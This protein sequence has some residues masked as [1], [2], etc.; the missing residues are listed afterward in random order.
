[1]KLSFLII[2]FFTLASGVS[3]TVISGKITDGKNQPIEG[4][5]VFIDGTYDGGTTN[6]NGYFLFK[7]DEIG[8]KTLKVSFVSYETFSLTKDVSELHNLQ[9]KL[10]D[11]VNALD[12]VVISAGTFSAGDNSK[13]SVLKPLDVVT[14]ASALGD[15]DG[16]LQTLPGTTTV[17]EDGRLFVRGGDATETQIFIDGIRVFTPYVPTTS[18]TPTRGRYSP[19]LFDGITFSTGGYSAEFGQALSSVLLLNTIDEPAQDKTDIALL[20][21]AAGLGHTE[22]W[23]ES[24]LSLNGSY[25]NLGPYYAI[26]PDRNDWQKPFCTASGEAVFRQTIGHGLLKVYGAFDTSAFELMQEDINQPNGVHFKLN[27]QN[28]YTNASFSESLSNDWSLM[29]GGSYTYANTKV[30]LAE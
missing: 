17:A 21:V 5:N 14:T 3:Q 23:E 7:T 10:R 18:N 16:A 6:E 29:A 4:A 15:F 30:G 27:N 2:F 26:F 12:T 22:K 25:I 8:V 19:F 1:M 13:I 24:S 11:D 28:F 9:I 20:T